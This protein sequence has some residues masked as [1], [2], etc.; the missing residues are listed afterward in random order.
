MSYDKDYPILS[1]IVPI[2]NRTNFLKECF[3]SVFYQKC[4]LEQSIEIIVMD[5]CSD[6]INCQKSITEIVN[7][8][9]KS[10]IMNNFKISI[11]RNKVNLGEYKNVNVGLKKSKGI[12][13]FILHDDDYILD[14]F[15]EV[16]SKYLYVNKQ[17][18][19]IGYICFGY[20]NITEDNV[21]TFEKNNMTKEGLWP[22]HMYQMFLYANPMH[23]HCCIYYYK[24]FENI[25]YFNENIKYYNDWEFFRRSYMNVLKWYYVPTTL[26]IYRK[27][28]M[29][30]QS[31]ERDNDDNKIYLVKMFI[32]GCKYLPETD[33]YNSAKYI[34]K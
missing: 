22:K 1:I 28:G 12:W 15:I 20:K 23:V 29:D 8:L 21:T 27:H 16:L 33:W 5:D 25:G 7:T 19:E 6:K 10:L 18:E 31:G 30:T 17:K 13:K 14:N 24:T 2:Y 9:D 34:F 32:E 3:E 26:V 11:I 4:K